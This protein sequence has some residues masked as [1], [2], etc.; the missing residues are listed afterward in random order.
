MEKKLLTALAIAAFGIA[1]TASAQTVVGADVTTNTSWSGEIVLQQPIFV[2]NG[3]RLTIQP[4]TIVRGQP[5]TQATQAG[6]IAGTPGALIVTQSGTLI[7]NGTQANPI[8]FTTAAT[9]NDNNNIPDDANA[10]GFLDEWEPGDTFYDDAPK[11]APLAP[12]N[13]AGKANVALW[14]GVVILGNAPTNLANKCSVGYGKCTV[15]GLTVPGFP[16][17]DATYGGLLP[18]D[19]SGILR[20]AS[21]RHAGDEIGNSNELNGLTLGGVG[22]GTTIE[23]V[24]VYTNFDDGIEWF[25][26]TVGGKRLAVFFAGDDS[27]DADEGYTGANQFLFA[28]QTYFNNNDGTAFGTSS[29]DKL[30]EF[31]GENYRPDN[32]AQNDNLN[33]RLDV[34]QNVVDTTPWPLSNFAFWNMTLLGSSP[35]GALQSPPASAA[36]TNIG[37]QFRNGGAGYVFNSVIVDTGAETAFEVLTSGAPGFTAAN[38]VTNNLS[39]MVCITTANGAALGAGTIEQTAITKGNALALELPGGAA[40]SASQINNGSFNGLVNEDPTFPLTGNGSGKLD[41]TLKT[42]KLNPRLAAGLVGTGGCPQP[43][44]ELGGLD[45]SATYRGAFATGGSLWTTGWTALSV[46]GILAN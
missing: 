38:N 7:A 41:G 32:A 18:H 36:A 15:E 30:C 43:R 44:Y 22:D 26:G 17:A 25:G 13:A 14:G 8:I 10:N 24:E 28:L 5:R 35:D 34:T 2:K 39:A 6:V 16:A 9:D 40:A 19:N 21:I 42:T 31:D 23:N 46:G 45:A 11:T 4:G 27:F 33:V 37:C 29:G 3:A 12:L 1:G 20:F